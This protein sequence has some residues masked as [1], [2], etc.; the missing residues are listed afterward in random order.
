MGKFKWLAILWIVSL[1]I[2]AP[3]AFLIVP[4]L[5]SKIFPILN[6]VNTLMGE[7]AEDKI[8]L[9]G[10]SFVDSD[11]NT[12]T[13][14]IDLGI[15]NSGGQ[16]MIFPSLNLSFNYG[17]SHLG[18]GWVNPEVFIPAGSEFVS[19]PIYARMNKGDAFNKFL[20]S[21]ISGGL[22]LS[23]SSGEAFVFLNTFGDIP[24]GAISLPLPS[25][26]LPAMELEGSSI[27][28]PTIHGLSRSPITPDNEVQISANVSDRGGGVKEVTLFWRANS[29]AWYNT[30]MIGLPEKDLFGGSS[31]LLGNTFNAEFKNYPNST[32][33]TVWAIATVS[34]NITGYP[35]GTTVDYYINITDAYNNTTTV[36]SS[37]PT[38]VNGSLDTVNLDTH[39]FSYQIGP[40]PIEGYNA[41]W[42]TTEGEGDTGGVGDLFTSLEASGI[43]ILGAMISGSN[44]LSAIQAGLEEG[45]DISTLFLDLFK[46]LI[47]YLHNKGIHPFEFLDQLLGLSGGIPDI[48]KDIPTKNNA[49]SSLAFD[50]LLEGGVGFGD[51]LNML[52]VN[53]SAVVESLSNS[54]KPPLQEG[55][56]LS[57]A[58]FNLLNATLSDTYENQSFYQ[59]LEDYDVYYTDFPLHI[60]KWNATNG[61][62]IN[63]TDE[64]YSTTPN[65]IP[66]SGVP[67]DSFYF[68]RPYD[69]NLLGE[70]ILNNFTIINLYGSLGNNST[71][72]I[73]F[74]WEYYNGSWNKL[75][76][77]IDE[78]EN[79]TRA[80][81][82]FF[83]PPTPLTPYKLG[84]TFPESDQGIYWIRLNITAITPGVKPVL[85]Q[86]A[87]S[88]DTTTYYFTKVN[89]DLFG[90]PNDIIIPNETDSIPHMLSTMNKTNGYAMKLWSILNFSGISFDEFITELN[91]T[92]AS[93][94]GP[95]TS[96][97]ILENTSPILAAIVYGMLLL[98]IIASVRGRKGVYAIP[99]KHVKK[100]YKNQLISPTLKTKDELEKYK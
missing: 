33:P 15:N 82:I 85:S 59:F 58:L 39:I 79:L 66:L 77:K 25:I 52:D 69:K 22:S 7:G 21:L 73:K 55:A 28:P 13:L 24:A 11:T 83:A 16:D 30:T 41:T 64:A 26:P 70:I 74:Q 23:I 54:I 44:K 96:Q 91:G 76:I 35:E 89:V 47:E 1:L 56:T 97:E 72:G 84:N 2:I 94:Q 68:G 99:Q 37:L 78:T 61:V 60:Y 10:F 57:E 98:G 29:S 100:W 6:L 63:Y 20:L 40:T 38:S 45:S 50:L 9:S 34:A 86:A 27:F 46:L 67:G 65:D 43:D 5:N 87:Y 48:D 53:I 8:T 36:P 62:L 95:V 19:V 49:N 17:S 80:G 75:P 32:I 4:S 92:Y 90:R 93:I 51:L 88:E 81:R 31:T 71:Q 18:V 14:R 12:L 3:I 42:D